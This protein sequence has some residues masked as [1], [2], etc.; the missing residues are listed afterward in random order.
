MVQVIVEL[1]GPEMVEK[2]QK[3][4][5]QMERL[6]KFVEDSPKPEL[7]SEQKNFNA[8]EMEMD[9]FLAKKS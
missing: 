9:K 8:M 1:A 6:M 4:L 7:L 3:T 2:V 5:G